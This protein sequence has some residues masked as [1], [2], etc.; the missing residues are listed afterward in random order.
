MTHSII[1]LFSICRN[2]CSFSRFLFH[3]SNSFRNCFLIIIRHFHTFCPSLNTSTSSTDFT[4]SFE[5]VFFS[6]FRTLACK[7][8]NII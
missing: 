4:S 3:T 8:F 2:Y 6:T 7:L 5:K 1:I